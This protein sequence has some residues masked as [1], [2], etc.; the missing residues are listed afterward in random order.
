M[1]ARPARLKGNHFTKLIANAKYKKSIGWSNKDF[2]YV[3][4]YIDGSYP[5]S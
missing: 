4:P 3:S 5:S 1:A 2:S